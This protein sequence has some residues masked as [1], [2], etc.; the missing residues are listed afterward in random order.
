V[1]SKLLSSRLAKRGTRAAAVRARPVPQQ[2]VT[3][4]LCN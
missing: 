1:R 3:C 2:A 4:V